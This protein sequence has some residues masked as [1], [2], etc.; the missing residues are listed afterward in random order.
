MRKSRNLNL[1]TMIRAVDFSLFVIKS[2]LLL[3]CFKTS[4][5]PPFF[6]FQLFDL[7]EKLIKWYPILLITVNGV[8]VFFTLVTFGKIQ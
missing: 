3:V 8:S 1:F 5:E 4:Q 6:R 7:Q 2:S